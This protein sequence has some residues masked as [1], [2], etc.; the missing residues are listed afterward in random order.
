MIDSMRYLHINEYGDLEVCQVHDLYRNILNGWLIYPRLLYED[1]G[2]AYRTIIRLCNSLGI[3]YIVISADPFCL[4][5]SAVE[6]LSALKIPKGLILCDTHHGRTPISRSIEFC[7]TTNIQSVLLRFNQRHCN[8]FQRHGMW[9][10]ATVLSPDLHQ[11]ALTLLDRQCIRCAPIR[12]H[13]LYRPIVP[14]NNEQAKLGQTGLFVGN[15]SNAHTFRSYQLTL[16]HD[17]GIGVDV[18]RAAT[19]SEMISILAS[20]PW[21]LNLPLNGD[22]NRRYIE[23]LLANIPVFTEYLPHSQRRFPFSLLT[24]HMTFFRYEDRL[25]KVIPIRCIDNFEVVEDTYSPLDSLLKIVK[26]SYDTDI[27]QSF[28]KSLLR[29][30]NNHYLSTT[31]RTLEDLA[32]YDEC[33]THNINPLEISVL[34]ARKLLDKSNRLR[35]S[36]NILVNDE[37]FRLDSYAK[38]ER[39]IL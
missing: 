1:V 38:D 33:L 11:K 39:S 34:E 28:H 17:S 10:D 22:F 12:K 26:S 23:I 13:D 18:K 35:D 25:S 20:Y 14:V 27:L 19:P 7:L 5:E 16:L 32:L 31:D 37:F 21:G 2:Y 30:Q 4:S 8:I 24:R 29:R 6:L 36:L 3:P 9:C 15:V